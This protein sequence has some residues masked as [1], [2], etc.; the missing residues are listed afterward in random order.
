[1]Y[2]KRMKY[3]IN[4]GGKKE[5]PGMYWLESCFQRFP[6]ETHIECFWPN[7]ISKHIL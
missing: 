7:T 6:D 2:E 3:V 5:K 1:M 4:D